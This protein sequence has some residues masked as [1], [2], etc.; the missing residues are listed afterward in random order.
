MLRPLN[1]T[2]LTQWLDHADDRRP[3][4]VSRADWLVFVDDARRFVE[5]RWL[6]QAIKAE[7]LAE[8][9]FGC[10]PDRPFYNRDERR[11]GLVLSL[12]GRSVLGIQRDWAVIKNPD[13]GDTT[14]HH[15]AVQFQARIKGQ[16]PLKLVWEIP[17]MSPPP[18]DDQFI[19]EAA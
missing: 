18:A 6:A 12:R 19:E 16:Q 8:E 5:E 1:I 4:G 3:F 10:D 13:G 11:S 2:H 17:S 15:R 9:L 14:M 7:W